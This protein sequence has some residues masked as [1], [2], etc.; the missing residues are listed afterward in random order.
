MRFFFLYYPCYIKKQS[1]SCI[2]KSF[3]EACLR[4]CY[5]RKPTDKNFMIRNIF[6]ID[7]CY[8]PIREITII[9]MI[10]L[11]SKLIPFAGK[12]NIYSVSLMK[13]KSGSTD[14]SK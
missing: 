6:F 8:V 12:N 9:C 13:S 10:C 7:F 11:L 2:I 5:T 4:E 3:F 14:S 1:S